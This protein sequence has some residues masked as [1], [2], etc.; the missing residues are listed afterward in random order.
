MLSSS[1]AAAVNTAALSRTQSV[2]IDRYVAAEMARQGLPGLAV[3]IYRNGKIVLAKGYGLANVELNMPMSADSV[4]QSGSVGK[5]FTATA[6]MMLVEQG[7][8]GLDDSITKYFPE[9]PAGWIPI[10]I[11]NLLSHTSGLPGYETP[12]LQ[13]PGGP[14]DIRRDFTEAELVATLA[15]LPIDF[16]AGD[17][18]A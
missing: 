6:V 5:S 12:E 9:S 11:A 16:K 18:W 1:L 10:T 13:K 14:L 3:G 8:V 4:L 17:N 15:K 2:A 7:K